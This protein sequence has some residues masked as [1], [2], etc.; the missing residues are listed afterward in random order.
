MPEFG[1]RSSMA[2]LEASNDT[3]GRSEVNLGDGQ[4][5]LSQR[6]QGG[7]GTVVGD[8]N[9]QLQQ[10]AQ[11]INNIGATQDKRFFTK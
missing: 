6:G 2:G 3:R 11:K 4:L 8:G 10:I 5:Q 7:G 1:S 9:P